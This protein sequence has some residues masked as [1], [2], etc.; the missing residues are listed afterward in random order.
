M[1]K[2][3]G[4]Y[5]IPL[6]NGDVVDMD[7]HRTGLRREGM[8]AGVNCFITKP[9]ISLAQAVVLWFL[10]GYGYDQAL[11]KGSQ[12]ATAETGILMGWV[13]VPGVL[14]FLCFIALYWYPLDGAAWDGIKAR[15]EEVHAE[16]ER[17]ETETR[18]PVRFQKT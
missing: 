4:M 5:L 1:R 11:A 18:R 2:P 8:Y 17:G 15:L 9:A 14:L 3:W 10:S 6:M 12:S 16:K 13:L 7:E